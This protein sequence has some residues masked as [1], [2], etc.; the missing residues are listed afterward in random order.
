MNKQI[1]TF[2]ADEQKLVKTGGINCYASNIVGYIEAHFA[3]GENWSGYDSIRAVW[4]NDYKTISTVLDSD[5]VCIVPH[6]V[7]TS[8]GK[9]MVNLVG[10][11][12]VSDELSDRLTTFS[13]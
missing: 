5:G 8:R 2:S 9:V 7:L 13:L 6:E 1:I 10:S 12:L 11:A 4:F 3:L